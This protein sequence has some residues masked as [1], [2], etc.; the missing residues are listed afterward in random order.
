M[1]NALNFQIA[2]GFPNK[3]EILCLALVTARIVKKEGE[4]IA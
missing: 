1:S 4:K 2:L 3:F